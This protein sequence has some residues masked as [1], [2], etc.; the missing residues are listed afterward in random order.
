MSTYYCAAC[1]VGLVGGASLRS[2][3]IFIETHR[4]CTPPIPEPVKTLRDEFAMAALTGLYASEYAVR[5]AAS[6]WVE[7][8]GHR[9]S[10]IAE[11]FSGMSYEAADAMLKEREA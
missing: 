5:K 7:N 8:G 1:G 6:D 10:C 2:R 11:W 9:E 4:N 3:G